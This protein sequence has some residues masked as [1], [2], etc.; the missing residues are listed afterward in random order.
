VGVFAN[1][2]NPLNNRSTQRASKIR[3]YSRVIVCNMTVLGISWICVSTHRSKIE[4]H[5][6]NLV[7]KK[8]VELTNMMLHNKHYLSSAS[9]ILQRSEE[10]YLSRKNCARC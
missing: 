1:A 5:I 9:K 4:I 2:L 7:E 6:D 3:A 8:N 10:N